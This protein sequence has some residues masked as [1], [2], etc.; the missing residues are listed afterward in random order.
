MSQQTRNSSLVASTEQ[1]HRETSTAAQHE[2][3]LQISRTRGHGRRTRLRLLP[4]HIAKKTVQQPNTV[5]VGELED[6]D[7]LHAWLWVM[8]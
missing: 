2:H 1:K 8:V 7:G 6:F 5:L 3:L 4:V